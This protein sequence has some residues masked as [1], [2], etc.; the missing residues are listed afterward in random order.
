MKDCLLVGIADSIFGHCPFTK[1]CIGKHTLKTEIFIDLGPVNTGIGE[2]EIGTLQRV[3]VPKAFPIGKAVTG[4]KAVFGPGV[5]PGVIYPY[6]V[7]E[8]LHS[9]LCS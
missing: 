6:F 9:T 2:I 1:T 4:H 8:V 5:N 3:G 7:D